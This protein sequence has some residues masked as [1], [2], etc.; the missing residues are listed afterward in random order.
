[1][2]HGDF[3]TWNEAYELAKAYYE[4]NNTLIIPFSYET[5]K[6]YKLGKWLSKNRTMYKQGLLEPEKITKLNKIGMVWSLNDNKWNNGYE[7]AKKYFN[8]NGNLY[9]NKEYKTKDGFDL[10]IWIVN[11]RIAYY[12]NKLSD[13]RINL[14]ESIGMVWNV[15][16]DKW[17]TGLEELNNYYKENGNLIISV[18]YVCE[19]GFNLGTWVKNIRKKYRLGELTKEQIKILNDIGFNWNASNG[20]WNNGYEKAKKFFLEFGNLYISRDYKIY[21]GF[22]LGNWISTQRTYYKKGKLAKEQIDLLNGIGMIWSIEDDKKLKEE[23]CLQKN[24]DYKKNRS[25]LRF[26]TINELRCKILFLENNGYSLV[27]KRGRL[28]GIFYMDSDTVKE[29]YGVTMDDLYCQMDDNN[30]KKM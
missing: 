30:C 17:T 27:D 20:L 8:D 23:I 21:D 2:W 10:G 9:V 6:G 28:S 4:E 7:Y 13:D 24:I 1:M 18:D 26:I 3:M 14:L 16:S 25:K 19:N 22:E 11:Q 5:K 29:I 12:L 15:Y